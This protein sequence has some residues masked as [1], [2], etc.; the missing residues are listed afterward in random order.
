MP[1]SEGKYSILRPLGRGGMG[2][3]YLALD[4]R[5]QREVAIKYLRTDLTED[6]DW[7]ERMQHE[8]LLLARLNHPNIVQIYDFFEAGEAPALVMEYVRGR[9]LRIYLREHRAELADKLRW[10]SEIS[11]GLA[12]SHDAGVVHCD[13][14]AENVLINAEGSAKVTDFG[15][16]SHSGDRADDVAALGVLAQE[17]LADNAAVVSPTVRDLL[18]R[19]SKRGALTA[20]EA[21]A[22]WRHAWLEQTQSE[23]PLPSQ[24]RAQQRRGRRRATAAL[25]AVLVVSA[26]VLAW[27]LR[28]PAKAQAVAILPPVMRDPGQLSERQQQILESAVAQSLQEAVLGSQR[29]SLVGMT[30]VDT[31]QGS[32]AEKLVAL[33]ADILIASQV[34]CSGT[35]CDL[36][37]QRLEKPSGQVTSYRKVSVIADSPLGTHEAVSR[38]WTYLFPGQTTAN[39]GAGALDEADYLKYT[40]LNLAAQQFSR[41]SRSIL[42]A[43]ESLLRARRDFAPL[44]YLYAQVALDTYE[45]MGDPMYLDRLER[46]L[47]LADPA[48]ARSLFLRRSRF[49]LDLYRGDYQAAREVIRELEQEGAD[50]A[51]VAY[52]TGEWHGAQDQFRAAGESFARA[53][54]LQPSMQYLYA[55]ARNQYWNGQPDAALATLDGLLKRYEYNTHALGLRAVILLEQGKLAA[56]EQALRLSL[57]IQPNPLVRANLGMV[58]LLMRNYPAAREQFLEA[59]DAD[60]RDSVVLLNL[61]DTEQLLGNVER[62]REL[63]RQLV[64]RYSEGDP[65]VITTVAAQAYAQLGQFEEA[66][67]TLKK[68]S[69]AREQ[70]SSPAVSAALVYTLAGQHLVALVEVDRALEAGV[71]GVMFDLPFFD[72]LCTEVR[73][74]ELMSEHDRDGRCEQLPGAT[75]TAGI[76]TEKR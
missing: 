41:S 71:S 50:D 9:N 19:L 37:L 48:L 21:A 58:Y 3:V 5:L 29:L 24:L 20:R 75:A 14:K 76:A 44:Y 10:L 42:A 36:D 8:A 11:A 47:E 49:R 22:Q 70:A 56:A 66:M 68:I 45:E 69:L 6:G 12:A 15:I 61:A 28:T 43:V 65:S 64:A 31:V 4:N 16:A 62:G 25:V 2:E 53:A 32:A 34:K 67:A 35:V 52:L 13:L 39:N 40:E 18:R 54:A 74:R 1:D 38:Q 17:L 59:Y 27:Q 60:S 55:Q 51:L 73:F 33:G 23:T 72:P 26:V 63:Y 57:D 46:T 30:E 7:H